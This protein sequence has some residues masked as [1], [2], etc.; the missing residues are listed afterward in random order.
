VGVIGTSTLLAPH[1]R[2]SRPLPDSGSPTALARAV[3]AAA[4]CGVTRLADVTGLDNVGVAVFQ[5]VRPWGRTLSVHQG[6]ALTPH[7]AMI[8]ALME[9]VESDHAETFPETFDHERSTRPFVALPEHE[10]APALSDFAACRPLAPSGDEPL[11]WVAARR[12]TDGGRL[13]TPLDVVRLD[14]SRP[15]DPRLDRTSNGLGARFDLEGATMK[16][17]LEVVERDAEQAWMATPIQRR[18]RDLMEPDS[19]PFRWFSDLR[20]RIDRAG[21]SLCIYQ[22]PA[23]VRVPTFLCEIHEAGAGACLRGRAMGVGCAPSAEAALL[24]G[25][26]EAAQSRLTAI[27]GVRDDIIYP[28]RARSE[29]G[30]FG[31]ALPIPPH[32]QPIRWSDIGA[33]FA[34]G[35]PT[36]SSALAELLARAG[37]PDAAIV[38]L[39]RPGREAVVVKAVVP[40]LG[41]FE[42]SRREVVGAV[43]S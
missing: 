20:Q 22:L 41:A 34:A 27:S 12:L 9:A 3:G 33:T 14:F 32:I 10:R 30:G 15:G 29:G 11:A 16:A 7:G 18:T 28:S 38:D 25:M 42:R 24:A 23:V 43:L 4:A 35:G 13:W 2:A 36:S 19:I 8:G 6:K 21:L 26:V 1:L 39:S 17:L 40:G 31:V 37:Y 5:A